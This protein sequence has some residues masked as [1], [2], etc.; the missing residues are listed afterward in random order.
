MLILRRLVEV[1]KGT[2]ERKMRENIEKSG[3]SLF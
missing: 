2:F 1:T 3:F